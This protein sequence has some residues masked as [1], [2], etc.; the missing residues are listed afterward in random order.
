[1]CRRTEVKKIT[2]FGA[3]VYGNHVP[4][5]SLLK[6]FPEIANKLETRDEIILFED[7][8]DLVYTLSNV[9]YGLYK[10]GDRFET[11]RD[12]DIAVLKALVEVREKL[13]NAYGNLR[14]RDWIL[15]WDLLSR[16]NEY[17]FLINMT[18]ARDNG[19]IYLFEAEFNIM[20]NPDTKTT[21]ASIGIGYRKYISITEPYITDDAVKY[22]IARKLFKT[23]VTGVVEVEILTD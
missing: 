10:S 4:P 16:G 14:K 12:F 20:Y 5:D 1:M 11:S 18:E 9:L 3:T 2:L 21:Q 19:W 22:E 13:K 15:L 23:P 6:V 7:F 8:K 17:R